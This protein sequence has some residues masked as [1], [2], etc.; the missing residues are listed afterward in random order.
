M[1]L[2][3][4]AAASI[5]SAAWMIWSANGREIAYKQ[6]AHNSRE[7][8]AKRAHIA[9][10]GSCGPLTTQARAKCEADQ[11]YAAHQAQHDDADLE[12]QQTTAVWTRY[13]GI[14]GIAGT[15]FGLIGVL[16]VLLTFRENRRAADEAR[17]ANEIALDTSRR[18]LR[19]YVVI[20]EMHGIA[21]KPDE[22]PTFAFDF[23][24]CG[25]TPALRLR[26]ISNP[27]FYKVEEGE[28]SIRFEL[29][30]DVPHSTM[31]L[32]A[33]DYHTLRD[34]MRRAFTQEEIGFL[35]SGVYGCIYAGIICYRD[36]F[37]KRHMTTFKGKWDADTPNGPGNFRICQRGN[38]AG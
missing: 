5:G 11:Y 6:A 25:Q 13:L 19:A 33:N 18:Q 17:K 23:M 36:I 38:H 24:N 32:A 1:A 27:F 28:P 2:A 10:Q 15:A 9:I 21:F 31:T 7:A 34:P 29:D 22:I 16:L 37:G 35:E 8:D 30:R 14:A 20:T 3:I 4:I 12:A 26:V